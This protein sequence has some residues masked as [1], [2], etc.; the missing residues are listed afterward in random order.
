MLAFRDGDGAWKASGLGLLWTGGY[1]QRRGA[2]EFYCPATVK[3][4]APWRDALTFDD[5][6]AFWQTKRAGPGDGDGI[7]ELPDGSKAI[8]SN[9]TLRYHAADTWGARRFFEAQEQAMVS[10]LLFFGEGDTARNHERVYHILFGGG[11]VKTFSDPSGQVG[12]SC[13]ETRGDDAVFR[14]LFDPLYTQD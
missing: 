13:R 3:N 11:S 6:E 5:N 10:D 9:Y 12:K 4:A 8:I 2:A 1:M 7:G 14:E